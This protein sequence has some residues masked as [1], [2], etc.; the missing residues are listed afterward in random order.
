ML[1]SEHSIVAYNRNRAVPDRLVQKSHAHY[2]DYA[3]TMIEVYRQGI[4]RQRGE[5]HRKIEAI[6]HEEPECPPRRIAAFC[7]LL[8][9]AST[10]HEASEAWKLRLRV[11][12]E[13]AQSHPLVE[14]PD[15]LLET[16]QAQVKQA[17]ADSLDRSWQQIEDDLY[18]DVL[19]CQRLEAFEGYDDPL[20]LLR[21]YN[22]AQLQAALYKAQRMIIWARED[23]RV[24]PRHIKFAKLLHEITRQPDGGYRIDVAGPAS[25]LLPTRRYGVQFARLI[26]PLLTCRGWQMQ[27]ELQTP[28]G[29]PAWLHLSDADGF[30]SHLPE[31]E[32][33]DSTVEAKFAEKFGEYREGWTLIREGAILHDKQKTFV[34][35]FLFR[36]DDG[37]EVLLEIVG[38][39]TPEY[40]EQKRQTLRRFADHH[41]LLA[42]PESS[43]KADVESERLIPYKT[44][45]K[46]QPV[47]EAL[48]R[49][50]ET[51]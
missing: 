16:N 14:N 32:P 39:W 13:A 35:D 23:F 43:I 18:A 3:R 27:A 22:V 12:Q 51:D 10:Y 1:T 42:V 48:A 20:D 26:P 19:S 9:D 8:D 6:F 29:R 44:A 40:L 46:L 11:F 34:P 49:C 2:V 30:E 7:K 31:P 50:R 38:F 33:Y 17:L 25:T 5:L 41:I 36:H 45:L 15:R 4:G 47:M 28:W 37:T 21:A 24:I